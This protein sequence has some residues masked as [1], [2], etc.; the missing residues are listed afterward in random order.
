M[1][2]GV[3][4]KG[5]E[6]DFIAEKDG[7]RRYIQVAVNVADRATAEREFGNLADIKDNYE[8][9]VVTLRDAA[10]NTYEGI[11]MLSLHKFLMQ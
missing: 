11:R 9:C 10:P 4:S 2:V 6:I 5:R 8:K 7:E 1:K 3:M